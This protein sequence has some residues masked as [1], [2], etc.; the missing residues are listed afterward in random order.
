M[1]QRRSC[2][3]GFVVYLALSR[4]T[5]A[6]ADSC[7]ELQASRR[8]PGS[9]PRRNAH[10]RI[11]A[12]SAQPVRHSDSA[13]NLSLWCPHVRRRF[14]CRAIT[15]CLGTELDS[16]HNTFRLVPLCTWF[17]PHVCGKSVST[18]NAGRWFSDLYGSGSVSVGRRS[19]HHLSARPRSVL[20]LGLR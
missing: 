11:S 14:G 19:D 8:P 18:G 12:C 10:R 4:T 20:I 2:T 13:C 5:A 17:G 6:L 7:G 15:Q 1:P 9:H 16:T 3:A